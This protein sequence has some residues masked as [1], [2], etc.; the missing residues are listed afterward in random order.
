M[1]RRI[2]VGKLGTR[3]TRRMVTLFAV[4]AVLPVAAAIFVAYEQVHEALVAQRHAQ[5]RDIAAAYGTAL[6]DRLNAADAVSRSGAPRTAS[7]YF[8]AGAAMSADGERI[9]FGRPAR[10]PDAEQVTR[11]EER[12]A[13]GER[14]LAV[15]RNADGSAAVWLLRDYGSRRLALELDPK[16][17]W[18]VDDL[19]YLTDLCVLGADGAPMTCTRPLPEDALAAVRGRVAGQTQGQIAWKG[20]GGRQL[21]G[22][23]EVFLRGRFATEPWTI[24]ASQPEQ[25]ALAPVAAVGAVVL[26]VVLLALLLAALLGMV[27]VRRTLEPLQALTHAAGRIGAGD[28]SERVPEARDEFGELAG[29]FNAMTERLGR[30]FRSLAAHSEIDAAILSGAELARIS[31]IV[32]HRM[33]DLA[34]A[35]RHHLLLADPEAEGIYAVHSIGGVTELSLGAQEIQRLL[36]APNGTELAQSLPGRS[37]FALPI[38]L[39]NRLAGALALAYDTER[40][41]QGEEVPLLRDLADRVAVAL[42]TARRDRELQHR[43]HYDALT[44]LPNRAYGLEALERAVVAAERSQ[45]LLAVLFVDLDGFSDVND[46]AGHAAGDALLVQA[47]G[48]LRRCVRRS[49]LVARLGGDEF[50]IVLPEIREPSDAAKAADK[51]VDALTEPFNVG[52]NV[53]VSAGVG[54]AVYPADGKS[55]EELLRHA[56]LAMYRAKATGRGQVA[57]FEASMHAEIRRRI[58]LEREL[59]QALDKGQFVLHYQP[60]L[61]LRTGR[62]VGAEALIRWM[63]PRRGLVPPLQFIDFAESSGLIEEIGRWAL[64]AAATQYVSWCA[65]GV[66]IGHVSV[67]VSARQ[68]RNAKFTQTVD[69]VLQGYLMPAS[70]L[71]LEI[72]ESAIMDHAAAEISL[73]ALSALGT[74]LELDDFGS[75]YSSLA[76]LQRLPI[77]AIK[78]DRGFVRSMESS[79]SA[80][81]VVKAAIDMAHALGKSV[82][83]EGVEQAG[84]AALL[85]GMGCDV[86]QGHYVSAPVLPA[87]LVEVLAAHGAATVST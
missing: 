25:Y 75:G 11:L 71:R 82:I 80:Q 69:A 77:A 15:S 61:D 49:D 46:S 44:Q 42:A 41:P 62:I 13:K 86:I 18:A 39:D 35:D 8:R 31:G 27:Q 47:A 64:R 87:K 38:V 65:Q 26:P 21:S 79:E 54:I 84:Q 6:I 4:C 45:R 16:F 48:R 14:A 5:L 66:R 76:Q 52:N 12:L 51:I 85:R 53:F 70:A 32:L 10:L 43:A 73:A 78:L 28:F 34:P 9:A 37:V 22:F 68:L 59:R 24:V 2:R 1:I 19:P 55:A 72:T 81:A 36:A 29:S 63:H 20:D 17:L 74:P 83:A 33:S 30:Q 23:S 40:R 3:I 56:D 7:E 67:N 60:Q 57:F 50:A 58:E